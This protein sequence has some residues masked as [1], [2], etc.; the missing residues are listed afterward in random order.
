LKREDAVLPSW[1]RGKAWTAS[2]TFWLEALR[3]EHLLR[4]LRT[5]RERSCDWCRYSSGTIYGCNAPSC[6]FAWSFIQ[7]WISG[8][9]MGK[10]NVKRVS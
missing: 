1:N 7:A 10:L 9:E 8:R 6:T 5:E 2:R 4:V 3:V